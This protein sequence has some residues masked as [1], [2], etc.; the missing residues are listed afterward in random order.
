[1]R[2]SQTP[3]WKKSLILP[4]S[5]P[6]KTPTMWLKTAKTSQM[7]LPSLLLFIITLQCKTDTDYCNDEFHKYGWLSMSLSWWQWHRMTDLAPQDCG[8]RTVITV[9]SLIMMCHNFILPITIF[10]IMVILPYSIWRFQLSWSYIFCHM[11]LSNRDNVSTSLSLCLIA[12]TCYSEEICWSFLKQPSKTAIG[13]PICHGLS[14]TWGI[15]SWFASR[16]AHLSFFWLF[17]RTAP[18]DVKICLAQW[19][20]NFPC[21]SS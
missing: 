3:A 10:F 12:I 21:H 4:Q 11:S 16:F 18:K 2:A 19:Q 15:T 13:D 5:K 8:N 6:F 20:F 17:Q 14:Y 1:M 7:T 9:I